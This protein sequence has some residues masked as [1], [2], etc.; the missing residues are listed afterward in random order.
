VGR[1]LGHD[2]PEASVKWK[3]YEDLGLIFPVL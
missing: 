1:I 3:E 2:I